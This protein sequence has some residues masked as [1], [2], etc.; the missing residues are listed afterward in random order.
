M[1]CPSCG[2]SSSCPH[3]RKSPVFGLSTG[4]GGGSWGP[5]D[6]AQTPAASAGNTPWSG[7]PLSSDP[8]SHGWGQ[9]GTATVESPAFPEPEFTDGWGSAP[10]T[11][12]AAAASS[13]LG[14]GEEEEDGWSGSS[15]SP[16]EV[17]EQQPGW[18]GAPQ[19]ATS[20]PPLRETWNEDDPDDAWLEE[21]EDQDEKPA[22]ER[23]PNGAAPVEGHPARMWAAGLVAAFLLGAGALALRPQTPPPPDPA[24]IAQERLSEALADGRFMAQ[25]GQVSLAGSVGVKPDPEMAVF[26]LR[27]A[28]G[29]LKQGAAP[30]EE[31]REA[32][33][34][35]AR[36]LVAAGL[37]EEGFS[38]WA[39]L[40]SAP[41]Y[42]A[43]SEKALTAVR[44]QL[45]TAAAT[46]AR[47][48]EGLLKAKQYRKAET[49][50]REAVR[51]YKMVGG[52]ASSRGLAYGALGYAN[53]G[54]GRKSEAMENLRQARTLYPQ[55]GYG[56]TLAS[57]QA[58]EAPPTA[59]QPAS[60]EAPVHVKASITDDSDYPN[61]TA[62]QVSSS[63]G[64]G[65]AIEGAAAPE[66][67]A[68]QRPRTEEIK[69]APARKDPPRRKVRD[70]LD[71]TDRSQRS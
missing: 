45:T 57:L 38:A 65:K 59:Q 52:K 61:G 23:T 35:L 18:L 21:V 68:P 28:I 24:V 9:G 49:A 27:T 1:P 56:R 26:Q 54:L 64:S 55:G 20:L 30:V 39:E 69:A 60:P 53:L 13:W 5:G 62:P 63:G 16:G 11:P 36:S 12:T 10:P 41:E 71:M 37:L 4:P 19:T 58:V 50:A 29:K 51:L 7:I 2:P 48:A 25:A 47:N 17:E 31:I 46:H 15:G 3:C 67:T 40:K 42:R 14:S 43:E 8:T 66:L 32:R 70:G 6:G 33:H 22:G 34:A 44:Q